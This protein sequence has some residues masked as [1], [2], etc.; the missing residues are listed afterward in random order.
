ML[1]TLPPVA[2]LVPVTEQIRM[3]SGE[4]LKCRFQLVRTTNFAGSDE[5]SPGRATGRDHG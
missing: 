3:T 2:K 5:A 4:Q 1:R